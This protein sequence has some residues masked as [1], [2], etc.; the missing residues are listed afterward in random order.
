MPIHIPKTKINSKLSEIWTYDL[1]PQN[2]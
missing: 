1:K 2:S